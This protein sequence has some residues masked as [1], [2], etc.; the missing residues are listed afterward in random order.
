MYAPV[1]PGAASDSG[2]LLA[3]E[4]VADS[5]VGRAIPTEDLILNLTASKDNRVVIAQ[6]GGFNPHGLLVIDTATEEAVQRIGLHSSWLG[7]AWSSDGSKLYVSGGNASGP[8]HTSDIA[9]IYV[10]GYANGRLTEKPVA[11]MARHTPPPTRCTGPDSP[12]IRRRIC[13]TR[14]IAGPIRCP[15][16]SASS[17]P[18]RARSFKTIPV[19]VSPYDLQF[20][21]VWTCFT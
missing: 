10:F 8:K 20:N 15:V 2:R 9:P 14:P 6:H 12:C 16:I 4:W 19:D 17:I 13:C 18:T 7:L 5:P 3:A 21:D 11:G 1:S